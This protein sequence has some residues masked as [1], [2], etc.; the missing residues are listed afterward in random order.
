MTSAY[1]FDASVPPARPANYHEHV[2]T[3]ACELKLRRCHDVR[4]EDP[5][6]R[7]AAVRRD[8]ISF[9]WFSSNEAT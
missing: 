2:C 7:F 8:L 4:Y 9:F 5:P 6:P 1:F 3:H